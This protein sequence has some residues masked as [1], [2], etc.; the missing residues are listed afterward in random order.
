MA[1]TAELAASIGSLIATQEKAFAIVN[2]PATGVG[3]TV[4]VASGVIPTFAKKLNDLQ[5]PTNLTPETLTLPDFGSTT[6]PVGALGLKSGLPAYGTG[7]NVG[8]KLIGAS[9]RLS[10]ISRIDLAGFPK[11][12]KA[13]RI[14]PIPFAAGEL[15][16]GATIKIT[17][18]V[19]YQSLSI[20]PITQ[21]FAGFA[22]D[23]SSL[24]LKDAGKGWQYVNLHPTTGTASNIYHVVLSP[25]I[26]TLVSNNGLG[27]VI[28]DMNSVAYVPSL[29]HVYD[30][31]NDPYK[32]NPSNGNINTDMFTEET[33]AE[34]AANLWVMLQ[35]AASGA[36]NWPVSSVGIVTWDLNIEVVAP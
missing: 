21:F 12:G 2:G 20:G 33:P 7:V 19:E 29:I 5:S 30:N 16:I 14:V 35:F 8:G 11:S 13:V 34:A 24:G 28:M 31:G 18:K 27:N 17:G 3:S 23:A 4:T 22:W 36:G 26:S 32:S 15:S 6:P 25:M 1:T 10:G 9:R